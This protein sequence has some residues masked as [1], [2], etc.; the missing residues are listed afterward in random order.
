MLE[1]ENNISEHAIFSELPE[2]LKAYEET[3]GRFENSTEIV[4]ADAMN[5]LGQDLV[6]GSNPP[7]FDKVVEILHLHQLTDLT[8][9][10]N[11]TWYEDRRKES[12][13]GTYTDYNAVRKI[14]RTAEEL[15][16][17]T[18][19]SWDDKENPQRAVKAIWS[20]PDLIEGKLAFTRCV[21]EERPGNPQHPENT[22]LKTF[23]DVFD[24]HYTLSFDLH[25]KPF[26]DDNTEFNNA[27]F[28]VQYSFDGNLLRN[29]ASL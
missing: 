7:P 19:R 6:N 12:I 29:V 28:L 9:N 22:H 16:L 4:V 3:I 10:I 27:S 26:G 15:T 24:D 21:V 20:H 17:L 25:G 2:K 18:G 8:K 5:A 1:T 23:F 13:S 14:T 11:S